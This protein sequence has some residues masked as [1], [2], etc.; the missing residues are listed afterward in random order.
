MTTVSPGDQTRGSEIAAE[1]DLT[2]VQ[3]A[4][5]VDLHVNVLGKLRFTGVELDNAV[6]NLTSGSGSSRQ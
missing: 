3:A 6:N 2:A 5:D 4:D 1:E